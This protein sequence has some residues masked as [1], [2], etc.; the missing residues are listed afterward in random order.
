MKS[1]I[2]YNDVKVIEKES[3]KFGHS[4]L[5]NFLSENGGIQLGTMISLAGTAGAG[6]TTLCKKLQKDLGNN[7]KSLFYALE[8]RMSS[9]ARQTKRVV[10]GDN[11]LIS[12]IDTFPTWSSFMK[13]IHS[14][15]PRMVI[16]DSLQ[17]AANLLSEENG[18]YKYDNYK[19]IV[20]DLY[21]WKDINEGI[22]ILIVQLNSE[23]KIEGPES[24]IFD[25]DCPIKLVAD[26]KTNERYMETSK[27]R[28]GPI[29]K[30]YY[31]FVDNDD[32]FNFH[33]EE[34]WKSIKNNRV[35]KTFLEQLIFNT[36][37][38]II[39]SKDNDNKNFKKLL[40]EYNENIK[41]ISNLTD[42][43]QYI[44]EYISFVFDLSKKYKF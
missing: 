18:K 29:G 10:T 12:D 19:T 43:K 5:D 31:E 35:E 4:V 11:Q 14:E 36:E 38:Q 40:K 26:Q 42:D 25:V 1:P 24:T 23:G 16:I 27:N 21:E 9:V 28:M 7:E 30:I 34:K 20:K 39:I 32:C 3:I 6:K 44:Q 8:S 2:S 13:Y 33:T 22:V 37:K 41:R 15:N 17:H